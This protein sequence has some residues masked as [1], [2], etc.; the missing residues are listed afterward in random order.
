MLTSRDLLCVCVCYRLISC[1]WYNIR[2]WRIKQN[3]LKSSPVNLEEYHSV[4]FTDLQ[5]HQDH[6]LVYHMTS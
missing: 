1:G 3:H 4:K 5:L 2:F 6:V